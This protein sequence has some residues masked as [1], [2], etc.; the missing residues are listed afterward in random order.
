MSIYQLFLSVVLKC[1]LHRHFVAPEIWHLN[2]DK[3]VLQTGI[4]HFDSTFSSRENNTRSEDHVIQMD[5]FSSTLQLCFQE[6][7]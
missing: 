1:L 5:R 3:I 7:R 4:E 6:L 2:S